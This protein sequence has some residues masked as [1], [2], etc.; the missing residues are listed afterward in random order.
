MLKIDACTQKNQNPP[1]RDQ[2]HSNTNGMGL[3]APW[4]VCLF[5]ALS[6]HAEHFCVLSQVL[7]MHKNYDTENLQQC[8]QIENL[9]TAMSAN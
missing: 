3:V 4:R 5:L 1:R 2:T 7:V 6:C 9:S 8:M